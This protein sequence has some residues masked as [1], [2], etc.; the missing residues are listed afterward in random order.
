FA[1]V[2]LIILSVINDNYYLMIPAGASFLILFS[3]ILMLVGAFKYFLKSWELIGWIGF[4]GIC[5]LLTYNNMLDLRTAAFGMDYNNN[6]IVNYNYETIEKIHSIQA[7]HQD[8][9]NEVQRLDT[10]KNINQSR[11][12]IIIAA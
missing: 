3:I 12:A 9:E 1:I 5:S 8:L 4:I 7:Y 11:T 2:I 6:K 10:W